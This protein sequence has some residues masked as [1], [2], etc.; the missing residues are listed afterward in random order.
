[1]TNVNRYTRAGYNGKEIVCPVCN[2]NARVFHFSWSALMCTIC[3]N[4]IKKSE[5]RL[6]CAS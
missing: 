4:S 1:M 3:H 2:N 5:W 6:E